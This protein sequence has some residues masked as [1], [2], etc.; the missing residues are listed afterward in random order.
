MTEFIKRYSKT[1]VIEIAM[2]AYTQGVEQ[3][4]EIDFPTPADSENFLKY[5]REYIEK[6]YK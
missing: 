3:G 1:E 4:L 2:H 6:E 5:I